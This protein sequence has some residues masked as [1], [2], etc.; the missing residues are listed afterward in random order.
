MAQPLLPQTLFFQGVGDPPASIQKAKDLDAVCKDLHLARRREDEAD[1]PAA[2]RSSTMRRIARGTGHRHRSSQGGGGPLLHIDDVDKE[3][4][5]IYQGERGETIGEPMETPGAR[6]GGGVPQWV[7]WRVRQRVTGIRG[8]AKQQR[9][10]RDPSV[11][12]GRQSAGPQ[13]LNRRGNAVVCFRVRVPV[14]KG[15]H[16]SETQLRS[17]GGVGRSSQSRLLVRYAR[18]KAMAFSTVVS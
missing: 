4:L 14:T 6:E 11:L 8:S 7:R 13:H 15:H 12:I 9:A 18:R 3:S 17:S 1:M 2:E 5:S 16:F 10:G